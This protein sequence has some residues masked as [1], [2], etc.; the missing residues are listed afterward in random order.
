MFEAYLAICFSMAAT[1]FIIAMPVALIYLFLFNIA[2]LFLFIV[3]V[4]PGAI[5]KWCY[6]GLKKIGCNSG[7]NRSL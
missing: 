4:I 6:D 1:F 7:K 2:C 5:L 3:L